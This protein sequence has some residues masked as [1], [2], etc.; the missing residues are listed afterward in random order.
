MSSNLNT[1]KLFCLYLWYASNSQA[2]DVK[3]VVAVQLLPT[4]A[5]NLKWF[6]TPTWVYACTMR[7]S[8]FSCSSRRY[9]QYSTTAG[10]GGVLACQS[11]LEQG[12]EC[13][14]HQS[15]FASKGN[16]KYQ[17]EEKHVGEHAHFRNASATS[18]H[19][20]IYGWYGYLMIRLIINKVN[21][22]Q[23]VWGCQHWQKVHAKGFGDAM[24]VAH[25]SCIHFGDVFIL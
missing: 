11:G 2:Q 9:L 18:I 16:V 21:D 15:H 13:V 8:G 23:S 22:T 12:R 4:P 3:G 20:T 10:V 5:L 7:R 14:E 19:D 17:C 24:H 1:H 25:I 6:P